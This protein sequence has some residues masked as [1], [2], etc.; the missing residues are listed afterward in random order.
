MSRLASAATGTRES[1][2]LDCVVDPEAPRRATAPLLGA[3]PGEGVG[4]ELVDAALRV[5][6]A[7]AEAGGQ[8]VAVEQDGPIGIEAE[9]TLGTVLPDGVLGFCADVFDRGGAVLSGPGGGRY[10]YDLRRRLGLF[11]KITPIQRAHGYPEASPLRAETLNGVDLLIVR[12]NLGG[13]YQ[14]SSEE[15]IEADGERLVRHVFSYREG[16]VRRFLNASARLAAARRGELTVVVKDAGVP[17]VSRLWRDCAADA[18]EEYGVRCSA[19]DVDL[20]AYQLLQ[21]PHAYD[22][23]A[24]PNLCGDVLGDLAALLVG[25]RGMA[26]G[27]SFTSQ[28]DAVYQTNHGA[29]HD[30][31]GTDRANPAGQLLSLAMLLRESLGLAREA[32]AVEEG[33]RRVWR[34]GS[35]PAD[36]GGTAGTRELAGL[37]A[38][39]AAEQ[40]GAEPR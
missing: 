4:P 16:D 37:V 30:I 17:G 5:L 24:A 38:E 31:A 6:R 32:H 10:V 36:L 3:L 19:V 25:S 12:E 22:V 8:A 33:I 20:L 13:V 1:A 26:F 40:L 28:G 39:A 35:R 9:R 23:V 29:A 2:W 11:L 27:G 14:G 21:R 7:L 15:D 34:A 18:A